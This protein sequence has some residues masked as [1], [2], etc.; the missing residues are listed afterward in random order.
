MAEEEKVMRKCIFLFVAGVFIGTALPGYA[1]DQSPFVGTQQVRFKPIQSQ[2]ETKGCTLAFSVIGED[3][4]YRNGALVLLRG[5]IGI[6]SE[7]Q[8]DDITMVL[9]IGIADSLGTPNPSLTVP[10]FAYLQTPHGSTAKS[11]IGQH[12]AEVGFRDFYF[13][14]ILDDVRRVYNDIVRGEQVTIGFNRKMDGLDV[15]VPLDLRIAEISRSTNGSIV[16][17]SSDDMLKSFKACFQELKK[18]EANESR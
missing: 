1:L 5:S 7:K 8:P 6:W 17:H 13:N 14:H 2:G 12:D 11:N 9:R 18:Y 4:E 3:H 10:H 16:R 15:L